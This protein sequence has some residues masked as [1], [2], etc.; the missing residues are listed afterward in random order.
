M[1]PEAGRLVVVNGVKILPLDQP[2]HL[3]TSFLSPKIASCF[4][5]IGNGIL[6]PAK[7]KLEAN[8]I[9]D[10]AVREREQ[11][12]AWILENIVLFWETAVQGARLIG[13][14]A[15]VADVAAR[16][17]GERNLFAYFDQAEIQR[18]QN[19]QI[20]QFVQAYDPAQEFVIALLKPGERFSSYRI[21]PLINS[22][23]YADPE[24]KK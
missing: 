9:P 2:L 11:D 7:M 18:F 3:P 5:C 23:P 20:D 13:R 22:S 21:R 10:W 4:S 19:E 1:Q 6:Q 24:W 16:S 17:M 14:G 8:Q 15:I 12:R